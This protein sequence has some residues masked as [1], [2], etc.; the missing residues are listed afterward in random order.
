MYLQCVPKHRKTCHCGTN[1]QHDVRGYHVSSGGLLWVQIPLSWWL[2]A[3]QCVWSHWATCS[4]SFIIKIV[5]G[6][7]HGDKRLPLFG[8]FYSFEIVWAENSSRFGVHQVLLS[9]IMLCQMCQISVRCIKRAAIINVLTEK[10]RVIAKV[11][12]NVFSW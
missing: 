6:A 8:V 12:L 1:V 2:L 3:C 7:W 4:H 10:E 11:S 9:K 5:V